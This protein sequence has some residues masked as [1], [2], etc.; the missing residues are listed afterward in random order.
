MDPAP[1][2]PED[3]QNMR[4]CQ[5]RYL[6]ANSASR[7]FKR[8][9]SAKASSHR[10]SIFSQHAA[11]T[12]AYEVSIV[13][14]TPST[15]Y[16]DLRSVPSKNGRKTSAEAD[17]D[18]R[19]ILLRIINGARLTESVETLKLDKG[20]SEDLQRYADLLRTYDARGKSSSRQ[21]PTEPPTTSIYA[22]TSST[23]VNHVR[24][25]S[26]LG[27]DVLACGELWCG[28]VSRGHSGASCINE[29]YVHSD[30]CTRH[31]G[32]V[33]DV[34]VDVRWKT[35]GIGHS[36]DGGR[37]V[38]EFAAEQQPLP[39]AHANDCV[40]PAPEGPETRPHT[41]SPLSELSEEEYVVEPDA[42]H[43]GHRT[44]WETVSSV[45]STA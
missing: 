13:P 2:K 19:K 44:S 25:V 7:F 35:V 4:P 26:P 40:G 20:L 18:E 42:Q 10:D 15:A 41:L 5:Q 11:N 38:V 28:G 39:G 34:T 29:R 22:T 27:L 33:F 43:H 6:A 37:W 36:K 1:G 31:Q 32:K 3:D 30:S 8:S 14:S 45:Y 23:G 17:D 12:K 16:S 9:A 21:S 24:L